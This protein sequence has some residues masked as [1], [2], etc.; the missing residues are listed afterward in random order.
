MGNRKFVACFPWWHAGGKLKKF[1]WTHNYALEIEL[2]SWSRGQDQFWGDAG[3]VGTPGGPYQGCKR[4]F[5]FHKTLS[6]VTRHSAWLLTW[7]Q[8]NLSPSLLRSPIELGEET[9]FALEIRAVTHSCV[10]ISWRRIDHLCNEAGVY[11]QSKLTWVAQ[12]SGDRNLM[13]KSVTLMRN[14]LGDET[15]SHRLLLMAHYKKV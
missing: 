15:H 3:A 6:L 10:A 1:L 14:L 13:I 8:G 4:A 7:H 11:H 12:L 5:K 9:V 2:S